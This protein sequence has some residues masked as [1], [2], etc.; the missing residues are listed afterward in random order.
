M[1]RK[2]DAMPKFLQINTERKVSVKDILH[3]WILPR[4]QQ[5]SFLKHE[6]K[7]VKTGEWTPI[8][9]M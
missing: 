8:N 6:N 9:L 7:K 2:I 4:F 3:L 1:S 5:F